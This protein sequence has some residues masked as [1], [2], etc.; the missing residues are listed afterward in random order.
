MEDDMGALEKL[1]LVALAP[2]RK[3]SATDERRDKMIGQLTEQ[4]KQAEAALGG[5]EYSRKKIIWVTD[6]DG[7]RKRAEANARLRQWWQEQESGAVQF[8][9]RY[10]SKPLEMRTG[11]AAIEVAKMAELPAVIKTLLSAVQQGELDTQLAMAAVSRR[12]KGR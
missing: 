11:L 7:T 6:T 10:G 9:V 3:K 12:P 5:P 4:L 8:A 1:K 2:K